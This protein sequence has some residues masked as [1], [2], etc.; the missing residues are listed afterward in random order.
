MRR[1]KKIGPAPVTFQPLEEQR[2]FIMSSFQKALCR[3]SGTTSQTPSFRGPN[4]TSAFTAGGVAAHITLQPLLKEAEQI[5][6][7]LKPKL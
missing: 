3:F 4:A 6:E 2:R 1:G 5:F 7:S